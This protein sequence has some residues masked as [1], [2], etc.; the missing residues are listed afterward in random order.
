MQDLSFMSRLSKDARIVHYATILPTDG[1]LM[2]EHHDAVRAAY[3][4][5][6]YRYDITNAQAARA[7]GSAPSTLSQWADAKY[8]GDNDT[9][10]RKV[11]AWMDREA[12]KRD[13][14]LELPYCPTEIAEAIRNVVKLA[15]EHG[16][17]AAI[18][19]PAGSG[20]TIVAK[21]LAQDY[22]G[23]YLYADE[24]LTVKSFLERMATLTK[25]TAAAH[26]VDAL[27]T[28]VVDK[29]RGSSRPIFVDEAHLLRPA[30][31]GR[32]RSIYDQTGSPVI[33]L[34]AYEIISRV[35]D[36]HVAGGRGQMARR[37]IQWN[38][39]EYFANVEDPGG[40]SLGRPLYTIDQVKQLFAHMP[41]KLTQAGLEMLWAI[42]CLPTHG[43]LG[44]A[45]DLIDLAYRMFGK[46]TSIGLD[47]IEALLGAFFGIR[48]RDVF[49]AAKHHRQTF[50]KAA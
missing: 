7:I 10:T 34:G 4:K 15:Y 40:G 45:K 2:Q 1:N 13:V 50:V 32:L 17:M 39:L 22:G 28:A 42:A 37:T 24:D 36:R 6:A 3:R 46:E 12:K 30:V 31:F 9:L 20:K 38:A 27:K 18:V 21:A 19:A 33:M 43:C 41:V 8:N 29:L 48:G 25:A 5:F 35:D 16:K 49:S 23:F 11:N 47:E 14:R 26:T 44:T